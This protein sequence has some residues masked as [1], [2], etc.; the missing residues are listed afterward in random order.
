MRFRE[1]GSGRSTPFGVVLCSEA[2]KSSTGIGVRARNGFALAAKLFQAPRWDPVG[3]GQVIGIG[4][5][6]PKSISICIANS[7]LRNA[8]D[9]KMLM[10]GKKRNIRMS[11]WKRFPVYLP[12]RRQS[13]Q[14][15]FH[16]RLRLPL[17]FLW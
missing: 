15:C 17:V 4:Y 3:M 2:V 13:R 5:R 7:W 16:V 14:H 6:G 10:K 8:G 12:E 11:L 1:G 9:H